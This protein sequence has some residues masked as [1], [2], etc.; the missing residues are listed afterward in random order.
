MQ[1]ANYTQIFV[2]PINYTVYR[3]LLMNKLVS[4]YDPWL[5]PMV[6]G[7]LYWNLQWSCE[8]CFKLVAVCKLYPNL[9][10]GATTS[11]K[12][13]LTTYK[14]YQKLVI[15]YRLWLKLAM[16][17]KPCPKLVVFCKLYLGQFTNYTLYSLLHAL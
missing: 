1:L 7:K 9:D 15:T 3:L 6:T 16:I 11:N 17:F 5:K 14:L 10:G 2:W 13:L 4:I 8:W 12:K